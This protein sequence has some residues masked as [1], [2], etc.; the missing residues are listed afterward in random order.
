[1]LKL[2]KFNQEFSGNIDNVMLVTWDIENMFPSIDNTMGIAAC[3]AALNDRPTKDPPTACIVDA[4]TIVLENNISYFNNKI[5]KQVS[6]SAM[7]P[8]H[9]C[10]YADI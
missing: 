7:G 10:S 1:M 4:L 8:N 6:G 9:S 2:D 5:Y 3:T